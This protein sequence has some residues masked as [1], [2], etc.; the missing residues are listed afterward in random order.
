MARRTFGG[1]LAS[2]FF[3]YTA[4]FAATAES[5]CGA[6][7]L[8]AF[9]A[10]AVPASPGSALVFCQR[11][12]DLDVSTCTRRGSIDAAELGRDAR[13]DPGRPGG[14]MTVQRPRNAA[15]RRCGVGGG[16]A[17]IAAAM[18]AAN[19]GARV[20]LLER[21]RTLGGDI[22]QALVR[23]TDL[24]LY[25]FSGR[26]RS[27]C[28]EDMRVQW[29]KRWSPRA[30]A[31]VE[32]AGSARVPCDRSARFSRRHGRALPRR[33]RRG[34]DRLRTREPFACR[35]RRRPLPDRRQRARRHRRRCHRRR[36]RRHG[37]RRRDRGCRAPPAR[38]VHLPHRRRGH[39]RARRDGTR[40]HQCRPWRMPPGTE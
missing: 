5:L 39:G 34:E 37:G 18:A 24:G 7:I 30:A 6:A 33:R 38:V 15:I 10:P 13:A 16:P 35:S 4:E 11:G 17:G 2:F 1:E 26:S 3:A 23:R 8:D 14:R 36:Q 28:A 9:H 27:R 29:P 22:W 21:E 12:G 25:V 31:G 32:W 20:L 19:C 40:T